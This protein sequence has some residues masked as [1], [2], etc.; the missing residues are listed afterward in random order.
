[1]VSD[2]GPGIPDDARDSIFAEFTQLDPASSRRHEGSGLGL[3]ISRRLVEAMGGAIGVDCPRG[4]GS[5]FWFEIPLAVAENSLPGK[6]PERLAGAALVMEPGAA[7]RTA[8]GHQLGAMG[9]DTRAVAAEAELDA[10]PGEQAPRV[11]PR[12]I[13]IA[14]ELVDQDPGL[15]VRLRARFGE[16][17]ARLLLTVAPNHSP[18]CSDIVR[19]GFSCYLQKPVRTAKLRARLGDHVCQVADGVRQIGLQGPACA[20]RLPRRL[21]SPEKLIEGRVLLA[22]DS[23]ANQ[24]VVLAMLRNTDLQIDTAANGREALEAL[25]R[26]PYDLVLMDVRMPEMDGIEATARIRSLGDHRS[27]IP[28]V[29]LTANAMRGDR[30]TY[31]EQGFDDY[32]AKPVEKPDLLD[33]LSKW[34]PNRPGQEDAAT[35]EQESAA[36][37][38]LDTSVLERLARD[39]AADLLPG[40]IEAFVREVGARRIRLEEAVSAGNLETARREAHSIKG[41]AGFFGAPD[42]QAA[43]E[44][45]EDRCTNGDALG[46]R[47]MLSSFEGTVAK[48]LGAY[49]AYEPV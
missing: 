37:G 42:L 44:A 29:A 3:A 18:D 41:A 1:M 36:P 33:M 16:A 48:T 20:D 4:G 25:E 31:L 19:E 28:V 43:A 13:L 2:S 17:D 10:L 26:F 34:L 6:A 9:I 23:P 11:P 49:R 7:S 32:L 22:E 5:R 27:S 35:G 24:M 47:E 30:E 38:T 12:W 14:R 39:T 8:L 45:L 15:P 46:A 21:P 40:M